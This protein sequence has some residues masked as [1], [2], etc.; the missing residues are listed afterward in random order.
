MKLRF[1]SLPLFAA[2]LLTSCVVYHPHNTDIPLLREQG[3]LHVDGSISLS[4][5]L[6]AAPAINANVAYAPLNMLGVQASASF[7][8]PG[9]YHLQAAAGTYFP[10]GMSV[11]E[12]YVGYGYGTTHQDTVSNLINNTY[13]TEGHYSLVFS[14]INF[15][16]TG[17]DDDCIDLGFGIKCGLMTPQFDKYEV[18]SDGTET[19][20]V[21]HDAPTFVFQPQMVFRFGWPN[22]K[23][24]FNFAFA[25]LS[26][27]PT[28]DNYF[29]YDR[30]SA[31]FGIHY[32]F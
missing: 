28:D 24:S 18:F 6:F 14:Q 23:F 16:W 2:L 5:P 9:I 22:F 3:D 4:A 32:K 27:W 17:L 1:L 19:L 30:F 10:F 12:C 31:G 26:G 13:R 29:N 21:R 7:T 8:D 20:V 15:G 11:L 25:A